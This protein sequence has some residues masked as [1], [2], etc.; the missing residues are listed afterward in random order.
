MKAKNLLSLLAVLFLSACIYA[1]GGR[2]TVVYSNIDNCAT[3]CVKEF[4]T[5]DKDTNKPLS[6]NVYKYD[7]NGRMLEKTTYRWS[8][9]NGWEGVQKLEYSYGQDNQPQTPCLKKWDKKNSNWI[10]E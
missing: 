5:C 2:S 8:D 9:K 6:K 3:G 1:N 10:E 4:M 7:P